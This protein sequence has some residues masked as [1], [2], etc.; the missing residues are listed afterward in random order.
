VV[1]ETKARHTPATECT[2]APDRAVP[3]GYERT[4]I[5]V[6]P[7]DWDLVPLS[8]LMQFQN[9]ANA[10][11]SAYGI[12]IPFINVLEVIT[13]SHLLSKDIPGLVTLSKRAVDSYSI[14]RGDVVF[15][16]TSETQDEVGL[17]AVYIDDKP[18]VFG[19]FV[20][21]GRPINNRLDIDFA[22]YGL[23]GP[24]IRTQLIALGQGAIRANVGQSDL[25]QV[26]FPLPQ[27]PE[28][29]A[30]AQALSDT[31]ALIESLRQLIIK[32]RELKR[33][34]M[35]ELLTGETRLP[36]FIGKWEVKPFAEIV[37]LRRD[38]IDPRRPSSQEF[39]VE[40]EH[41][42]SG[43][44]FLS[45]HTTASNSISLKS[46]FKKN[47]VLFGK[48][49]SYLRKFWLATRDGVCPPEIWVF[50]SVACSIIPEFLFQIVT[51]DQFIEVSSSAYGTH[52]PRSD[53]NVI[54]NYEVHLPPVEEQ[55]AIAEVLSEMDVEIT[56][57]EAKVAKTRQL[58]QGMMQELLTGRTR[59]T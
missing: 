1:E 51:T 5:G 49:R 29:R 16:R 57:L 53:W 12:G 14:R 55:A 58:K 32:K 8:A 6:I 35:Q 41:I 33:G 52:M 19:G 50:A 37:R 22:G 7:D 23:R 20:I 27:L 26:W 45:G 3:V 43:T 11:K 28:Q 39:C 48:L 38:R 40:L 24:L 9:G 17:A 59:L 42:E 2:V 36:G 21:R 18:V 56:T 47:D 34:A 4:D 10:D 15:N 30:V 44:G 31:D 25:K 13:K 54:K 46:V